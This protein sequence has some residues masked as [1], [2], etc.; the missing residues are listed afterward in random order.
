ML[1]R[2]FALL[3]VFSSLAP[4]AAQAQFEPRDL[5]REQSGEWYAAHLGI[6]GAALLTAGAVQYWSSPEREPNFRGAFGFERG[7]QQNFSIVSSRISDVTLGTALIAP[8]VAFGTNDSAVRFNNSLVIYGESLSLSLAVDTVTKHLVLR[9]RPYAL[10]TSARARA[11]A[12]QEGKEQNLSFYSGHA[13][14]SFS[15]ATAGGLIFS[16]SGA[17]E[18][19]QITVW[20]LEL[21]LASFT[22][23][24]RM[25]AGMHFTSDV[26]VGAL[27]GS[28]FGLG[29]PLLQG[30][31]PSVSEGEWVAMGGG[32][33]LGTA[34]AFLLP[35]QMAETVLGYQPRVAPVAG[36][37]LVTLGSRW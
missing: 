15:A 27:M 14:L 29:V 11:F 22:S 37:A 35:T 18:A 32:L 5:D 24:A 16:D 13:A 7:T 8:V 31:H 21:S 3:L 1:G 23:H 28:A 30:V 26:L 4:R 12:D 10:S 6:V 33:V 2:L 17:D 9:A 34:A 19:S 36:G 20:A 25:R